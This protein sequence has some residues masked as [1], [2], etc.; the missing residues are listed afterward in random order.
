MIGS[1]NTKIFLTENKVL[2]DEIPTKNSITSAS[3]FRFTEGNIEL[4]VHSGKINL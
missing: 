4:K 1:E 3:L 2:F